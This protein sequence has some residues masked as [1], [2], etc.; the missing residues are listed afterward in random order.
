[1]SGR[2]ST[3]QGLVCVQ[4]DGPIE[5]AKRSDTKYCSERCRTDKLGRTSPYVHRICKRDGCETPVPPGRSHRIW[6]S[7]GCQNY[8]HGKARLDE[9]MATR[10]DRPC[11]ICGD[12]IPDGSGK[13]CGDA[14]LNESRKLAQRGVSRKRSTRYY[15]RAA[16]RHQEKMREDPDGMRARARVHAMN[17]R[18]GVERATHPGFREV[19]DRIVSETPK[20]ME[21]DHVIPLRG[22]CF[23]DGERVYT[24]SGLHVP[25]NLKHVTVAENRKKSGYWYQED[26]W[27]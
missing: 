4:C 6:C 11:E 8:V 25:W 21:C 17:R 14:C 19:C 26:G 7:I 2:K 18:R 1:M 12:K 13:Y 3:V 20:G 23:I 5:N 16:E 27:C 24:V 9:F 10:P 15:A 22:N